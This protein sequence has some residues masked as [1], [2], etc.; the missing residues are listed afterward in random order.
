MSVVT[1]VDLDLTV[2]PRLALNFWFSGLHLLSA[3]IIGKCCHTWLFFFFFF[4]LSY[5]VYV[6]M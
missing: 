3:L 5:F 2:Q 6:S 1:Q 4:D